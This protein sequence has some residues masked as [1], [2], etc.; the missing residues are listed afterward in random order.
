MIAAIFPGQGSQ[1]PGM[2]L[3]LWEKHEAARRVFSEA[4]DATGL[5]LRKLCFESDEEVLRQTQNTQIALFACSV[6]AFECLSPEIKDRV[7]AMA[8]HSVGE[9]A[10]LSC[11]GVLDVATGARLVRKRGE[12]MASSGIV[13]PGTMAAILGLDRPL[14]EAICSETTGEV[15]VANDNCPGQLVI[16]GEV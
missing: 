6:A 7:R 10:A 9:Y 14:L 11:A 15:V 13:R 3:E 12:L 4:S 1:K 5:D 16:S 2:G 8:G